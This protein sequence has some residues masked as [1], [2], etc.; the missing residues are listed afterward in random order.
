VVYLACFEL[1]ALGQVLLLNGYV[2]INDAL[3]AVCPARAV[4]F[5]GTTLLATITKITFQT[6]IGKTSR[7]QRRMQFRASRQIQQS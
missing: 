3:S 6:K 1:P 2:A 5:P 4:R 7:Y